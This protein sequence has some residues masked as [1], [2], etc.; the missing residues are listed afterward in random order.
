MCDSNYRSADAPLK[1]S[2][3]D[4]VGSCKC[5][6]FQFQ[7]HKQT[8]QHLNLETPTEK[9]TREDNRNVFQRYFESNPAQRRYKIRMIEI[10]T[11]LL[12]E[13]EWF[14]R[15][16]VFMNLRCKKYVDMYVVKNVSWNVKYWKARTP[17]PKSN[18]NNWKIKYHTLQNQRRQ[19]KFWINKDKHG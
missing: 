15:K 17:I 1:A 11:D 7:V 8:K 13:L 9:W 4:L 5:W 3:R 14:Y 18:T 2:R 10:L 12:T 19:D 16:V 6:L